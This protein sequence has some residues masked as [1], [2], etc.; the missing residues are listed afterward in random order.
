MTDDRV[1]KGLTY[2]YDLGHKGDW[3][4]S[5]IEEVQRALMLTRTQDARHRVEQ[6]ETDP[7]ISFSA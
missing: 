2:E 1:Y 7:F 6:V 3:E 4:G 5:Y